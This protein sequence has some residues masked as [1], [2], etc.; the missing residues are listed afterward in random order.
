MRQRSHWV[1]TPRHRRWRCR[2]WR[3]P[4]P[5]GQR[6][7]GAV[8]LIGRRRREMLGGGSRAIFRRSAP[9]HRRTT[10]RR[11]R[12]R[13]EAATLAAAARQRSQT[14]LGQRRRAFARSGNNP[15]SAERRKG[16]RR[17]RTQGSPIAPGNPR[18]LRHV[19]HRQTS[20]PKQIRRH[21]GGVTR[22]RWAKCGDGVA[23]PRRAASSHRLRQ[24]G[25]TAA[26]AKTTQAPLQ[27]FRVGRKRG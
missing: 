24:R 3:R 9:A 19:T 5:S 23:A 16:C 21:C 22:R 4:P 15:T 26:E 14:G 7:R 6:P 18:R 2:R 13:M 8:R 25:S 1:P 17:R 12:V 27:L 11:A 20:G 10:R